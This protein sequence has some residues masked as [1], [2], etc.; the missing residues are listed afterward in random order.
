[1]DKNCIT[2]E[3]NKIIEELKRRCMSE[4]GRV[5]ANDVVPATDLTE[6]AV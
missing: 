5:L 6:A 3:L 1:M 4:A 2:L